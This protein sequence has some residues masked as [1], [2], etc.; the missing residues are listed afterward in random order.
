M[1]R[2]SNYIRPFKYENVLKYLKIK[3]ADYKQYKLLL[4]LLLLFCYSV[5]KSCWI[6]YDPMVCSM[7]GSPVLHYIPEFAQ[8]HVH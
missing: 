5:T 3:Y 7:P 1:I 6:L 4:L 8:I 2:T